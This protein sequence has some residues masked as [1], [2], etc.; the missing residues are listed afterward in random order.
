M[1]MLLAMLEAKTRDHNQIRRG[2][3]G[4]KSNECIFVVISIAVIIIIRWLFYANLFDLALA[5][6]M[7]SI[8]FVL[9]KKGASIKM[10]IFLA[11]VSFILI[12]YTI[13]EIRT[14]IFGRKYEKI[15][16]ER[17]IYPYRQIKVLSYNIVNKN[18]T[19]FVF[20]K[21][22][23]N[24]VWAEVVRVLRYKNEDIPRR[25]QSEQI[26]N[27]LTEPYGKSLFPIYYFHSP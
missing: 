18:L 25:E 6:V 19:I 4:M 3:I 20:E 14:L 24:S 9:C 16:V 12:P 10:A 8:V 23:K 5:A 21:T 15:E 17:D 7:S 27:R 22:E 11:V 13:V 1:G 26:Y 2:D